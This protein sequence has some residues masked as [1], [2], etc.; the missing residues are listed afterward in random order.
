MDFFFKWPA[1]HTLYKIKSFFRMKIGLF[2]SGFVCDLE[3]IVVVC[4]GMDLGHYQPDGACN[5]C[6]ARWG[7]RVTMP[8]TAHNMPGFVL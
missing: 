6:N 7:R 8:T 3:V 1:T 2:S 4:A 5:V